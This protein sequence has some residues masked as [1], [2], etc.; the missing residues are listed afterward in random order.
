M[1]VQQKLQGIRGP[2]WKSAGQA[3]QVA[4]VEAKAFASKGGAGCGVSF[5][6][7]PYWLP[8]QSVTGAAWK[9]AERRGVSRG[10]MRR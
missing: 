3:P 2:E 7:S 9:A 5:L 8:P 4:A 6:K 10:A 1:R